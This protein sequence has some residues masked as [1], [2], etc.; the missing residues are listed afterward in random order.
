MSDASSEDAAEVEI[1]DAAD[2]EALGRK[3]RKV[4][5]KIKL[6]DAFWRG[7]FAD[8]TGRAEMWKLLQDTHAFEE[9]FACGPN[10]FPQPE[11]TWFGAG[12]QAF[13]MRLYQSWCLI[14]LPGVMLMHQEHDPRWPKKAR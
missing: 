11:A 14:D 2:V 1:P 4:R 10:G 7:V 6:A 3:Q 13:G 8:E 9:R 12:E 5:N